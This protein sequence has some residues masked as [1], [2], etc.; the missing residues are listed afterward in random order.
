MT[1]SESGPIVLF[2]VELRCL[3]CARCVGTLETH[4]WPWHGPALLRSSGARQAIPVADWSRLHC[5]ACGGNVYADEVTTQRQYPH[6]SWDDLDR[7]RPKARQLA[8]RR[9]DWPT[10]VPE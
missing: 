7:P 10:D 8:M 1:T 6:V 9:I 4:Q 3:Q 2:L 5:A